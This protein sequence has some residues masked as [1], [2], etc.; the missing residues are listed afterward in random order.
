MRTWLT[1]VIAALAL[2]GTWAAW[3]FLKWPLLTPLIIS[4]IVVVLAFV[5]WLICTLIVL[6]K[7]KGIERGVLSGGGNAPE[8]AAMRDQFTQYLTALKTSP[9]GKGA[10]AT[11]PWFL[12]LGAP[13]SGKTTLLQE[14]GLAFSSLGHGLRSIR[15]IGGTRNCDWWFSDRAIFLDTAGR[16]TTQP[17]DQGE[18]LSFLDLIKR[19][20]AGLPVNFSHPRVGPTKRGLLKE[21]WLGVVRGTPVARAALRPGLG[22]VMLGPEQDFAD[23]DAL[24]RLDTP[25]GE[26]ATVRYERVTASGRDS[27][28]QIWLAKEHHNMPVRVVFEDAS[29]LRLEQTITSLTTR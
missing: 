25:A 29:G 24:P 18:W 8:Q 17:E 16:Y 9:S 22:C 19:N 1:L 21:G 12:V 23:I 6:R 13:G 3:W 14:S 26:F 15:G 7:A 28:A 10:L 4:G 5:V 27:H 2:A 11:L 20:R